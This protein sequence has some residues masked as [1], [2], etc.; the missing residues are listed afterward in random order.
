MKHTYNRKK[1]FTLPEVILAVVV[2]AIIALVIGNPFRDVIEGADARSINA[3]VDAIFAAQQSFKMR[4]ENAETVF[5]NAGSS[6]ARFDLLAP[7]I[8]GSPSGTG[9]DLQAF[10]LD[11]VGNPAAFDDLTF[12]FGNLDTVPSVAF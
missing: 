1:G 3:K 10:L 4:V 12:E 11:G 5:L 6:E 2:L 9:T 8:P 7:Y